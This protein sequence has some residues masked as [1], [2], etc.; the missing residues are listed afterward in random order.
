M[1]K[2]LVSES[3]LTAIGDAI[4]EKNEGTEKYK[5]S[6][7]ANAIKAIETA[8]SLTFSVNNEY[9]DVQD[10]LVE[11]DVG[12]TNPFEVAGSGTHEVTASMSVGG[13]STKPLLGYYGGT[14][15]L[16]GEGTGTITA[17]EPSFNATSGV[18]DLS[19]YSTFKNYKDPIQK[20]GTLNP[21]AQTFLKSIKPENMSKFINNANAVDIDVS[22][23]DTSNVTSMNNCFSGCENL[24]ALNLTG[25]DT[26]KV[27]SFTN[28]FYYVGY[29]TS[30]C[31]V[32]SDALD[33]SSAGS[34]TNMFSNAKFTQPIHLKNVPSRFVNSASGALSGDGGT[35]GTHYI[36]DSTVASFS[37]YGV[38]TP[39]K[40]GVVYG[41]WEGYYGTLVE[42]E[43]SDTDYADGF[44]FLAVYPNDGDTIGTVMFWLTKGGNSISNA[45]EP[46]T[47]WRGMSIVIMDVFVE[48]PFFIPLDSDYV[49]LTTSTQLSIS[50]DYIASLGVSL[51]LKD[52]S[53]TFLVAFGYE[54]EM[55]AS[56][57]S[58]E[59]IA[60]ASIDDE[61][62]VDTLEVE[63]PSIEK[64]IAMAEDELQVYKELGADENVKSLTERLEELYTKRDSVDTEERAVVD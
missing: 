6:E 59:G 36:I 38:F 7:M 21:Y 58:D 60:V 28:M 31:T 46:P 48:E 40:N 50:S 34:I 64:L 5:P 47:G 39:G 33:M 24:T 35:A 3:N 54:S 25:W 37:I 14:V 62:S 26:S 2:V 44:A 61:L 11:V 13:G 29:N 15:S 16:S 49:E 30:G 27:T 51:N 41:Y 10:T 17:G 63:E 4:R 42:I 19:G 53:K 9:A 56:L 22:G 32:T 20:D 52:S 1:A 45:V 8:S 43:S 57:S 18:T 12:F 55:T 23:M